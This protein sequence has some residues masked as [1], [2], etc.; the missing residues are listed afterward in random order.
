MNEP[1]NSAAPAAADPVAPAPEKNE[2]KRKRRTGLL[3]LALVV[4]IGGIGWGAYEW[5]VASKYESTDDAYAQGNMV[6]ITPQVGGTVIAIHA[7]DTDHVKAGQVLVQLD[8]ADA[9]LALGQAEAALATAVRQ[10]RT[11]DADS[12]AL[13]AQIAL[14][15]ADVARAEAELARASGDQARRQR[16]AGSGAVSGEEIQHARA[17]VDS[18]RS[19]VTAAQ[20]AVTA[21]RE[22]LASNRVRT[23]GLGLSDQPSVLAAAS[24]LREAWLALQRTTLVAPV[25]GQVARRTAQLGQRIAPGTPLMALVP[26][27]QIWVDANFKEGQL[28]GIRIGQHAKVTADVYGGKIEFDGTVAGL[29]AGTG[30]AFALLPAQNASGNWIKVVQ[31]VPVRIEIDPKQLDDH[32]LRI[33]LSMNVTVNVARKPETPPA[34]A[35]S[36]ISRTRVYND[37]DDGATREIERIIAANSGRKAASAA[38]PS[39][40]A[41]PSRPDLKAP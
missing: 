13:Q 5:L 37:Q 2:R 15:Q 22:Q 35:S 3:L 38:Q 12:G 4:V 31:R 11:V 30:S 19:A 41:R 21:A 20:A 28:R 40:P 17:Q 29:G 36:A 10:V 1:Q 34:N 32:P 23:E 16:L 18:A 9:K 25:N 39:A 6:Q 8:P 14:R 33:G 26:L 7:D 24:K 27:D